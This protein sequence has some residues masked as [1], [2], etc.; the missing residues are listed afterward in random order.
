MKV[1]AT[2]TDNCKKNVSFLKKDDTKVSNSL[3]KEKKDRIKFSSFKMESIVLKEN[4]IDPKNIIFKPNIVSQTANFRKSNQNSLFD[5][6]NMSHSSNK[7]YC[8]KDGKS[9]EEILKSTAKLM[10]SNSISSYETK[11]KSSSS[12]LNGDIKETFRN[13]KIRTQKLL[14]KYSEKLMK[15]NGKI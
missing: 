8:P 12:L 5:I 3:D 4:S 7:I 6:N 13:L 11:T 10:E 14:E 15:I 9:I 1:L 2:S